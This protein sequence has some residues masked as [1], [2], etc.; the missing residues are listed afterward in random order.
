MS[1]RIVSVVPSA[2]HWMADWRS[3]LQRSAGRRQVPL[4]QTLPA[5][6]WI[7]VLLHAPVCALQLSVVQALPSLQ[8]RAVPARQVPL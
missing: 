6:H 7:R 3:A 5:A 2:L 4:Q 1:Q 8:L